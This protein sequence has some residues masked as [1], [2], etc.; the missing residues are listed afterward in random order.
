MSSDLPAVPAVGERQYV[1]LGCVE[2]TKNAQP[3]LRAIRLIAS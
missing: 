1:A 2:K 3:D